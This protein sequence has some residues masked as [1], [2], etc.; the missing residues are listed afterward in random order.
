MLVENSYFS[1]VLYG[2]NHTIMDYGNLLLPTHLWIVEWKFRKNVEIALNSLHY[3]A[4]VLF[5]IADLKCR[6]Q[7]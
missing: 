2:G 3:F 4:K 7:S 1:D 6:H 5:V